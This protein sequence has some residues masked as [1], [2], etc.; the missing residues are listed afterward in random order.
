MNIQHSY[1][2]QKP[3]IVMVRQFD[4]IKTTHLTYTNIIGVNMY[5]TGVWRVKY[6]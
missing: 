2:S 3:T 4:S 1:L 6:K 5:L